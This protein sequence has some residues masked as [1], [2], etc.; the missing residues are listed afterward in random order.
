MAD[1]LELSVIR[2]PRILRSDIID[3]IDDVS[4]GSPADELFVSPDSIATDAESKGEGL[5]VDADDAVDRIFLL[6]NWRAAT[7]G[8]R[9]PF[10]V[11]QTSRWLEAVDDSP[12]PYLAML[13]TTI[14]H[15]FRIAVGRDPKAVFEDTVTRALECAGHRSL[16]F[17][18]FRRNA[19][20]FESA[21]MEAGSA[22][23]LVPRPAAAWRSARAQDSGCDVL[24]HVAS[25]YTPRHSGGAWTLIGQVT[26][27][28]SDTW[29]QKLF[30]VEVPAWRDRLGVVL[31]P[32]A[33]LAIPHHAERGHLQTLLNNNERL[34]LDR[35]R[36]VR[37]LEDVSS[38]EL[39][40]LRAV[41]NIP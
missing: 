19:S 35:M 34:V 7:L 8:E 33:F 16:N 23:G 36:L 10:R 11:D 6:L 2:E 30:D 27:G 13:C 1:F 14:A 3:Y 21:V 37:M 12:T 40:I 20:D 15:A 4:W 39:H 9:Y 5:G 25:G 22:I 32:Q 31:P 24:A 38:D 29:K 17:S 28:R 18:R 26:C 41:T